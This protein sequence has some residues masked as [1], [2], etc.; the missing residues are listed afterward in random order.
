M[1]LN[2]MSTAEPFAQ[3]SP[4]LS[5]LWESKIYIDVF[6]DSSVMA[7][8]PVLSP[9]HSSAEVLVVMMNVHR[10]DNILIVF[11]MLFVN[12][13]NACLPSTR[14]IIVLL[15]CTHVGKSVGNSRSCP[16]S[17]LLYNLSPSWRM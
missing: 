16:T 15:I 11:I 7:D 12:D 4:E 1:S 2:S 3:G 13:P 14:W 10:T 17:I 9:K 6:L 8:D 5:L